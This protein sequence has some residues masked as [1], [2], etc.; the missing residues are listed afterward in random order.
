MLVG[1]HSHTR[2][3]VGALAMNPG[4]PLELSPA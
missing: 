1:V 4:V 3:I 2:Q